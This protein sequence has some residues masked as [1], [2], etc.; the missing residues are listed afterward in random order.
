MCIYIVLGESG[1][2]RHPV[3]VPSVKEMDASGCCEAASH[4]GHVI[5]RLWLSY[6]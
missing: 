2:H 1:I 3:Q 6:A 4:N 5:I